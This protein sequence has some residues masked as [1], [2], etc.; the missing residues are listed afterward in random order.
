[1]MRRVGSLLGIGLLLLQAT[2]W[3]FSAS[4]DQR[5]TH[6]D[7][8]IDCTVHLQ[9]TFVRIESVA[10]GQKIIVLKNQQGMFNYLPEAGF[11]MRLSDIEPQYHPMDQMDANFLGAHQATQLGQETVH[12]YPCD[13][14]QFQDPGQGTI[15]AWVWQGHQFPVKVKV[16]SSTGTTVAELSNVRLGVSFPDSEFALP[17]GVEVMDGSLMGVGAGSNAHDANLQQL[18][19]GVQG[20]E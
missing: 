20:E 17:A 19:D 6:G 12:G 14:Y 7:E 4:Y 9:D 8:V 16:E 15:T 3:G 5:V 18:M 2:A 10:E 13:L 11:A 1:M